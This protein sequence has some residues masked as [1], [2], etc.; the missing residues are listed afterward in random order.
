MR[1]TLRHIEVFLAVA[2]RQSISEAAKELK[3]SQSATSAALQEF[4]ARYDM[5]LFDRVAKRVRLNSFGYTLR[6]QA[7]QLMKQAQ[8][9]ESALVHRENHEHLSVGASLTIGNYLA[10]GFLARF[11][12]LYPNINVD[13]QVGNTPEI[14]DKVLNFEVDIGLIEAEVKHNDLKLD[15]WLPDN[16]LAFCSPKHPF[17]KKTQ[18]N[19]EDLLSCE[20]IVREPES[21][22]RQTFDRAFQGL[23]SKIKIG[24]E[25]KHNEA[26]KNAV[27]TGLGVGVL[28]EITIADEIALKSLV[29]LKIPNRKMN[30]NF[31]TVLHRGIERSDASIRWEQVCRDG[32][33]V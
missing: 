13:I 1:Y 24:A 4:E 25:L 32:P 10:F 6:I 5:Q 23:L 26:I 17:A 22:H 8:R 7:E 30:R 33:R 18:L 31:Y 3:L 11:R 12:K 27:K 28:S 2:K 16:M 14:I 15:T 20:W 9:F 29:A 21:A 19:D